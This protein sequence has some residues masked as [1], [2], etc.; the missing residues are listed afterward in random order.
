M[1]SSILLKV[2][3]WHVSYLLACQNLFTT[4][5]TSFKPITIGQFTRSI[6]KVSL[7]GQFIRSVYKVNL[8][9]QFTRSI[10][11][12]SLQGQYTRSVYM[13]SLQG[14]FT[15]S[16]Y[17][18]SLQGQFTR[19]VYKVSL[20]GQYTTSHFSWLFLLSFTE[21]DSGSLKKVCR[22]ADLVDSATLRLLRASNVSNMHQ[23]AASSISHSRSSSS[24]SEAEHRKIKEAGYAVNLATK[25]LV[26]LV[27][28]HL[29]LNLATNHQRTRRMLPATPGGG[30]R[31]LV[32]CHSA[33]SP[34][35]QKVS[36]TIARM[37][38]GHSNEV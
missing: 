32:R 34:D 6:Y 1:C 31:P 17:K 24:A 2:Y 7:Q 5:V 13:V 4:I 14:Q 21:K 26:G 38:M 36:R 3:F 11:K 33:R 20:Q 8:Q 18:V 12:V 35:K 16:V 30:I 23:S 19:S 9:G 27:Q 22:C 28:K 10:H 25:I 29:T 15:R 37:M